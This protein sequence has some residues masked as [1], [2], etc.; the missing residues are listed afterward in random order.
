M[1]RKIEEK[2]MWLVKQAKDEIFSTGGADISPLLKYI[3]EQ[4]DKAREEGILLARVLRTLE[5]LNRPTTINKPINTQPQTEEEDQ[6]FDIQTEDEFYQQ[7][8]EEL[9]DTPE[10]WDCYKCGGKTEGWQ[11]ADENFVCEECIEVETERR[12]S[13][14]K[15]TKDTPEE[16]EIE[17]YISEKNEMITEKQ[18][19]ALTTVLGE[20]TDEQS[21][22]CGADVSPHNSNDHS[23]I[24]MDCKEG[25]AVV[26]IFNNKKKC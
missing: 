12:V 19:E 9:Q 18:F 11:D 15:D 21:N 5:V 13:A 7:K 2:I 26:Y 25:C 8:K 4:L 10:E 17:V 20:P 23:S 14:L 24:C 3:E 6:S 1:E 22:C 16:T